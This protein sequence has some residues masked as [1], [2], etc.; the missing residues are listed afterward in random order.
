M[1]CSLIESDHQLLDSCFSMNAN[2]FY[3]CRSSRLRFVMGHPIRLTRKWP[4]GNGICMLCSCQICSPMWTLRFSLALVFVWSTFSEFCFMRGPVSVSYQLK[5]LALWCP[6]CIIC[7]GERCSHID[8]FGVSAILARWV[9]GGKS[10]T[11]PMRYRYYIG[12]WNNHQKA[13]GEGLIWKKEG[14]VNQQELWE[15]E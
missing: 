8:P 3:C 15:L 10:T 1:G 12:G 5:Q 13:P 2:F 14:G 6:R 7:L 4:L 9:L 11:M